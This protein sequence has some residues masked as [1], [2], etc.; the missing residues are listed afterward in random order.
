MDLAQDAPVIEFRKYRRTQL[1]EMRPYVLGEPVA[2][3]SISTADLNAGSPRPGDMIA[4]NPENHVDTW[5]VA[6][7]YFAK[8]YEPAE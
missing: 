4:R 2:H 8:N 3:V 1:A 7:D 5:L 6:A